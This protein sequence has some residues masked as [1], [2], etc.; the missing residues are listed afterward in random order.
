MRCY[1]E[2]REIQTIT[3]ESFTVLFDIFHDE[4]QVLKANS[5]V[6]KTVSPNIKDYLSPQT[7]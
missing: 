1:N 5:V 4:S 2:Y 3:H 6:A 7:I